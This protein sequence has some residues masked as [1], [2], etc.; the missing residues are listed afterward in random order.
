MS[1]LNDE[2]RASL[3]QDISYT[4][5]SAHDVESNSGSSDHLRR[6]GL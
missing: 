5:S 3:F 2:F 6:G 4:K 1:L